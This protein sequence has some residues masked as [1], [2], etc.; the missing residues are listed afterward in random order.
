MIL[1]SPRRSNSET[2][3]GV[4]TYLAADLAQGLLPSQKAVSQTKGSVD[5]LSKR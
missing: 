1:I 4:I 3:I 2:V 5:Y